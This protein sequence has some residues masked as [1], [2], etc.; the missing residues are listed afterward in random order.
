MPN[1]PNFKFTKPADV[2]SADDLLLGT[3]VHLEAGTRLEG[4]F[5][6]GNGIVTFVS[7]DSIVV[8][9]YNLHTQAFEQ[10]T[11]AVEDFLADKLVLQLLTIE[12]GEG[13]E[14]TGAI[15]SDM[16]PPEEIVLLTQEPSYNS[17]AFTFELPTDADFDH[18]NVYLDDVLVASDVKTG[19]YTLTTLEELTDYEVTFKT[20]DTLGN[21]SEGF[22]TSVT[23]I[24]APD[25]EPP[26]EVEGLEA[27]DITDTTA[28]LAYGFPMDD[29]FSH[30]RIM[31]GTTVVADDEVNTIFEL[32]GLTPG[33]SYTYK[34]HTVDISGN[35]SAGSEVTFTTLAPVEAPA[36]EAPTE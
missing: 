20:V 4:T 26:G 24:E 32:T 35:V 23:T 27:I 6:Q 25:L 15:P 8:D 1:L 21:I 9:L 12:D 19:A 30:V 31:N 11:V 36:E 3:A 2:F 28:S 14:E 29:D 10:V 34:V 7:T 13:T 33:T 17:V 22:P 18:V 5:I 16:T